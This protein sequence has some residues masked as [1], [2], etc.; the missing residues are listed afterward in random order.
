MTVAQLI[1]LLQECDPALEVQVATRNTDP[2]DLWDVVEDDEDEE[3]RRV[4]LYPEF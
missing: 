4:T 3:H 1:A 2:L